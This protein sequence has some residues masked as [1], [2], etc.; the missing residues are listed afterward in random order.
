[1]KKQTEK[2]KLTALYERLSHG[3][4]KS[5]GRKAKLFFSASIRDAVFLLLDSPDKFI[6][7]SNALFLTLMLR[8]YSCLGRGVSAALAAFCAF[9]VSASS[10]AARS[11]SSPGFRAVMGFVLSGVGRG[12]D[13][14]EP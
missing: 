6:V 13:G 1:M 9:M 12:T 10:T 11:K 8:G 2:D 4:E 3:D 14:A 7:D 5:K